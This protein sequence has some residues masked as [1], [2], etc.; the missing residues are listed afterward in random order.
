MHTASAHYERLI[1][2]FLNAFCARYYKLLL[3]C[4]DHGKE[5]IGPCP[6]NVSFRKYI[7][8]ALCYFNQN[9][10]SLLVAETVV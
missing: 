4:A 2:H 6:R 9:K 1:Q 7:P 8:Q 5:V 3:F 10:V